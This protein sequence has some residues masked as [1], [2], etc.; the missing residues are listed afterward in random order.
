M[1]T[2]GT[3]NDLRTLQALALTKYLT[4]A[5]ISGSFYLLVSRGNPYSGNDTLP[6]ELPAIETAKANDIANPLFFKK[7]NKSGSNSFMQFVVPNN[8]GNITLYSQRYSEVVESEIFNEGVRHI[9]IEVEIPAN[10]IALSDTVRGF[11]LIVDL[12][13]TAGNLATGDSYFASE[14]DL[15]NTSGNRLIY[16]ENKAK[17][18]RIQTEAGEL[19]RIIFAI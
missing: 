1:S 6:D 2:F 13:T 4:D 19:V 18:E 15:E 12:Y 11:N 9:F 5:S 3:T 16:L 8:E 10:D 7:I 17:F 14:I